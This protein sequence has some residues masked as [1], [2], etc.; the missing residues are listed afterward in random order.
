MSYIPN[1]Y[2]MGISW[3]R[4]GLIGYSLEAMKRKD[5]TVKLDGLLV[6][7]VA[8]ELEPGETLTAYVR[9]AVSYRIRRSRM[10]KAAEAYRT[11]VESDVE[12]AA[13]MEEWESANLSC[14]PR[15][16]AGP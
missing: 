8:K 15:K 14:P 12:L 10:R 4:I 16:K 5:T 2:K 7:E 3:L 9:N 11:A 1:E 13:E 6:E